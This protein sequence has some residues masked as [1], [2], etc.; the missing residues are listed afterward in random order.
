VSSQKGADDPPVL[1]PALDG[2]PTKHTATV[3][4]LLHAALSSPRLLPLLI[5]RLPTKILTKSTADRIS[6][7]EISFSS[8]ALEVL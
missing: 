1:G 6:C 5:I 2:V 3:H 4:T 8:L 7:T